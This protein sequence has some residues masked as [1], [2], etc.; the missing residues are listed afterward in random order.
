MNGYLAD[1]GPFDGMHSTNGGT[2]ENAIQ[3]WMDS[4]AARCFV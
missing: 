2:A 1:R 3:A 4:V